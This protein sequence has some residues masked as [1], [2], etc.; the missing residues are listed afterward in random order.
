MQLQGVSTVSVFSYFTV[1]YL[2]VCIKAL[3]PFSGYLGVFYSSELK[4][5]IICNVKLPEGGT[6]S[7][8]AH[9]GH[10]NCQRGFDRHNPGR[11]SPKQ[12]KICFV[13]A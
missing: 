5:S 3:A 4:F 2:D 1:N 6:L 13:Q 10:L 7:S 9:V 12:G 11:E 8:I